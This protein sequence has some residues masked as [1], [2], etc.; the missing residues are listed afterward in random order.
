MKKIDLASRKDIKDLIEKKFTDVENF[1]I[2]DEHLI[3]GEKFIKNDY[4]QNLNKKKQHQIIGDKKLFIS[5]ETKKPL[6]RKCMFKDNC[7]NEKA[8]GI[9][10]SLIAKY[11][12]PMKTE[13]SNMELLDDKKVENLFDEKIKL[14]IRNLNKKEGEEYDNIDIVCQDH[15]KNILKKQEKALKKKLNT[16]NK[17]NH[18]S[19]NISLRTQKDENQLLMNIT[20]GFR[21]KNEIHAT[22]EQGNLKSTKFGFNNDWIFSLRKSSF[23]IDNNKR[24]K[25]NI[26]EINQNSSPKTADIYKV[27]YKNLPLVNKIG[28][29]NNQ[30]NFSSKSQISNNQMI[31]DSNQG[32]FFKN[33]FNKFKENKFCY[34]KYNNLNNNEM[35]VTVKEQENQLRNTYSTPYFIDQVRKPDSDPVGTLKN[36]TRCSTVERKFENLN[37]N[38]EDFNKINSLKVK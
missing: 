11:I 10:T 2:P 36:F 33:S 34:L 23:Y 25:L 16:E 18:I 27:N 32:F 37:I 13:E 17:I 26:S 31:L 3:I 35:Y 12:K 7:R 28:N 8:K 30:F 20:D 15:V 14:T 38:K 19:K 21:L 1:L 6:F 5:K 24:K 4:C 29:I 22:I 9:F